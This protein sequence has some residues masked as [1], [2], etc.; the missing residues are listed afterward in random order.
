MQYSKDF[1]RRTP[2]HHAASRGNVRIAQI[3]LRYAPRLV[4][5]QDLD[6]VRFGETTS[7]LGVVCCMRCNT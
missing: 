5:A 3:L 4:N 7:V 1:H 2:L 6:G